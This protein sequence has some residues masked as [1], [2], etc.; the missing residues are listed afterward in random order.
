METYTNSP[1]IYKTVV[2]LDFK[3]C[4]YKKIF[5]FSINYKIILRD[6]NSFK[7]ANIH[8]H[9]LLP[10]ELT[11]LCIAHN[12]H[13]TYLF[14]PVI[15]PDVIYHK[16]RCCQTAMYENIH[17]NVIDSADSLTLDM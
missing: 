1:L 9:L 10:V 7:I 2:M 14:Q 11:I 6:K 15:L 13:V 8:S 16:D 17:S 3:K 12:F 4:K 5:Y